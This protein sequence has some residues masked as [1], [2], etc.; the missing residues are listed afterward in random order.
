MDYAA[1]DRWIDIIRAITGR[2]R[3]PE[4]PQAIDEFAVDNTPEV[5]VTLR[6]SADSTAPR[7]EKGA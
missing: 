7:N 3:L 1:W 6:Q 4:V 2:I 5:E